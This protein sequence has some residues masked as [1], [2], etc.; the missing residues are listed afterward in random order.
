MPNN[1]YWGSTNFSK[2]AINFGTP[3]MY[4]NRCPESKSLYHFN[5]FFHSR[6]VGYE[7]TVI[8]A[9]AVLI[10]TSRGVETPVRHPMGIL[11]YAFWPEYTSKTPEEHP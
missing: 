4:Q 1:L 2:T 8:G 7:P 5:I 6:L 3:C 11:G 9:R 10:D